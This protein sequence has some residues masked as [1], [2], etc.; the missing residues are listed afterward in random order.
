LH[1]AG[2]NEYDLTRQLCDHRGCIS[3]PNVFCIV[4]NIPAVESRG[5][6]VRVFR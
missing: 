6:T 5:C 1:R 4:P 3:H 2:Q